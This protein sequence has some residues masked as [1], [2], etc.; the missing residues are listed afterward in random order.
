[1]IDGKQQPVA[2]IQAGAVQVVPDFLTSAER[3]S[4]SS[5]KLFIFGKFGIF[6]GFNW[7]YSITCLGI[8][9][10]PQHPE[11][12]RQ[13][14]APM[15]PNAHGDQTLGIVRDRRSGARCLAFLHRLQGGN[16]FCGPE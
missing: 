14:I 8:F 1:V 11:A 2:F 10:L 13:I 12:L 5:K 7:W 15:V 4:P 9:F 16:I 6:F 3:K